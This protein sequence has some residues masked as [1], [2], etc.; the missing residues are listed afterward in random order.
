MAR[1]L[2]PRHFFVDTYRE[3]DRGFAACVQARRSGLNMHPLTV[4][5][6]GLLDDDY[7]TLHHYS[8]PRANHSLYPN[9]HN[10][11][12]LVCDRNDGGCPC[13]VDCKWDPVTGQAEVLCRCGRK[14]PEAF[15]VGEWQDRKKVFL[16]D[17]VFNELCGM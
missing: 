14:S 2:D 5:T 16:E 7:D 17:E 3:L 9:P 4:I 10:Y 6:A 1:R 12:V 11:H 15:Y 8:L 13:E